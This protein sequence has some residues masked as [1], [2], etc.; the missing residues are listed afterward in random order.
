MS[1]IQNDNIANLQEGTGA[2]LLS[3]PEYRSWVHGE[4]KTLLCVGEVGSGKTVLASQVI[5]ILRGLGHRDTLV[6][7]YFVESRTR[8]TEEQKP[9]SILANFLK[10]LIYHNRHVSDQTRKSFERLIKGRNRP[11]AEELLAFIKRETMGT[12]KLFVVIDALDELADSCGQE[13]LNYLCQLQRNC[14]TSLMATSRL[15]SQINEDFANTFPGYLHLEIRQTQKDI[16][17]SMIGQMHR[18][19]NIV[20]R[21]TDL[22]HYITDEIMSLSHGVYVR[23]HTRRYITNILRQVSCC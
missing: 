7:Y 21:D 10:Q 14:P 17:A 6:L 8:E 16:E 3:T 5:D 9:A 19:P 22:Q 15:Y 13:V 20:I 2:S 11:T 1:T 12:P 4:T 23:D 18:L